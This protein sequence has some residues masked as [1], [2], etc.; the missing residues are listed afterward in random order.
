MWTKLVN[1][2]ISLCLFA[3]VGLTVHE[4]CHY[5][6]AA[7][8]GVSGYVVYP[9]LMG[10]L[11]VPTSSLPVMGWLIYPSGGVLCAVIL[12]AIWFLGTRVGTPWDIDDASSIYL[13]ATVQLLYG[14]AETS[15]YFNQAVYNYLW[16][17]SVIV[18]VTIWLIIYAKRLFNWWLAPEGG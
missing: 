6:A 9:Q 13:I 10:G 14:I 17:I 15:L 18:G 8:L 3:I 7:M 4:Y 5:A 12:F 16:W 1:F 11:F 2:I